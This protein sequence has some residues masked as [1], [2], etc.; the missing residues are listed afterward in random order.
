MTDLLHLYP[1]WGFRLNIWAAVSD[2][3][4][5][6]A[7]ASMYKIGIP[8][9]GTSTLAT[10]SAMWL[11]RFRLNDT[12]DVVVRSLRISLD[13]TSQMLVSLVCGPRRSPH[14][15]PRQRLAAK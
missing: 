1:P 14:S 12:N 11:V 9:D 2:T 10:A 15:L 8:G 13:A 7:G 6:L 3:A 5:W 4:R